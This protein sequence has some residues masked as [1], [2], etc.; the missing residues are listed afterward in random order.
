MMRI[1]DKKEQKEIRVMSKF[2]TLDNGEDTME[3][4]SCSAVRNFYNSSLS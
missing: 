1:Y 2:V 4:F 3:F